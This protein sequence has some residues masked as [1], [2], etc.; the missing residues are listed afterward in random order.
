MTFFIYLA[1]IISRLGDNMSK[2]VLEQICN[3]YGISLEDY[4]RIKGKTIKPDD[5]EKIMEFDGIDDMYR[6]GI[7]IFREEEK[8]PIDIPAVLPRHR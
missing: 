8:E 6:S 4:G 2:E 1:I 5:V 7:V 3:S